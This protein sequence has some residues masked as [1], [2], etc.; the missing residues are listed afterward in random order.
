MVGAMFGPLNGV[1]IALVAAAA[2]AAIAAVISGHYGAAL[3]LLAAIGIHGVGWLFLY[4]KGKAE[5]TKG[6]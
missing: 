4:S 6:A 5:H 1:R 3:V 2:L